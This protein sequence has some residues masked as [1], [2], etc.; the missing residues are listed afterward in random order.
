MAVSSSS[1]AAF[2][3]FSGLFRLRLHLFFRFRSRRLRFMSRKKIL[4]APL[5][6]CCATPPI[7]RKRLFLAAPRL[8]L[9]PISGA[10]ACIPPSQIN[11]PART[12]AR[13]TNFPPGRRSLGPPSRPYV[14]ASGAGPY[15]Q[16]LCEW[17][18]LILFIVAFSEQ[19][20]LLS[21]TPQQNPY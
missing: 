2:P 21:H 3:L 19:E 7:D 20:L 12:D 5:P 4:V 9:Q 11:P 6:R 17:T 18:K 15:T 1:S 16:E 8:L 10:P 13:H 14:R